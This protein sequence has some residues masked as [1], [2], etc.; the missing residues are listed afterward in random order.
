MLIIWLKWEDIWYCWKVSKNKVIIIQA[1]EQSADKEENKDE[2][3][4]PFPKTKGGNSS[5]WSTTP[6]VYE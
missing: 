6:I 4:D 3:H 5:K 1:L 2:N